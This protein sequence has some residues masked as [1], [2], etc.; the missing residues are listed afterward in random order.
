MEVY[1]ASMESRFQANESKWKEVCNRLQTQLF[2]AQFEIS[3]LK[4]QAFTPE[5]VNE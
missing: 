2:Q 3:R 1:I 4:G 5:Y